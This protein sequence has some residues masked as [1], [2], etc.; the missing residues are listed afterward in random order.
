MLSMIAGSNR[1]NC[2]LPET[3]TEKETAMKEKFLL[4]SF[5]FPLLFS[6][7]IA[8]GASNVDEIEIREAF[9][10]G[11]VSLTFAAVDGGERVKIEIHKTVSIPLIIVINKGSTTFDLHNGGYTISL[12]KAKSVNLA[13]K[14]EDSVVLRQE[15]KGVRHTGGSVMVSGVFGEQTAIVFK[16]L[17]YAQN[18]LIDQIIASLKSENSWTRRGAVIA[19]GEIGDKRAT[20][21]LED[22]AQNDPD[23]DI[24]NKAKDSLGKIGKK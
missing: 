24:R 4:L 18:D 5:M 10:A 23:M 6:C 15:A 22:I 17:K 13:N 2:Y 11:F 7:T 3:L 16:K 12:D 8:C 20:P 14:I 1:I 9:K 21:F 19:L